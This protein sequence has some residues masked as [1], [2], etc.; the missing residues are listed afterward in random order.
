MLIRWDKAN[1]LLL[2][3]Q[4]AKGIARRYFITNGF[5][6]ALT[7]L[8]LMVGFYLSENVPLAVATKACFGAAV[9]LCMSGLSSAY[10]SESAERE[11]ELTKLEQALLSD[12]RMSDYGTA[13]RLVPIFIAIVNGFSPLVISMIIIAPVWIAERGVEFQY[14]PFL[15]AIF[16]ACFLIFLLGTFLARLCKEFWLLTGLRSLAIAG[17]TV[18]VIFI[19][20]T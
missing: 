13:S 10:L 14:S 15:L 8:G 9:A 6:G 1:R 17:L 11:N 4:R 18:F 19:L 2:H 7:M 16:V 20:S 12:L 5:D 3:A